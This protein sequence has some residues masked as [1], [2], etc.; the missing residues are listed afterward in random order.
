MYSHSEDQIEF[1]QFIH[2]FGGK[3]EEENRWVQLSKLIPWG[4]LEE[5]Y[6]KHFSTDRGAPAKSARMAYGSLII[7]EKCKFVDE[8]L[9]DQIK[10]NPYLQ[11]FIGLKEYQ[12]TA[13]LDSSTLV[14]FRKRIS[15]KDVQV[16]IES[17]LKKQGIVNDDSD[18]EKKDAPSHQGQLL[19]DASCAPADISF[20]TDLKLLNHSRELTEEIIDIL[21]EKGGKK[22]KK[23]RTY[24]KKARK[25]FLK[26]IRRKKTS[27]AMLRSANQKQLSFVQRNLR[28]I[29]QLSQSCCLSVLPQV[30]YKKLLVISEVVRQ[31]A[32]MLENSGSVEGRIVNLAQPHIRPIVRGKAGAKTEFGAKISLSVHNGFSFLHRVSFDNYNEGGDLIAQAEYYKSL[33][34]F[35]PESIHADK[36]YRNR[37]NRAYCRD[38]GIRLSGP[39]LGRPSKDLAKNKVQKALVRKDEGIRNGVE[40]KFGQAKR[41]FTLAKVMGK[42]ANTS[43]T[44]I[45]FSIL[46]LNL[47]KLLLFYFSQLFRRFILKKA[48]VFDSKKQLNLWK[49]SFAN[50]IQKSL[51]KIR[52]PR[53]LNYLN[54]RFYQ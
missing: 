15:V 28:H 30:L 5:S 49:K 31:Q 35:Y 3:L 51:L 10:E 52:F 39:S 8:E 16:L 18:S 25:E 23:P 50:S 40:G 34:G 43:S 27:K 33:H 1:Y 45:A 14:D 24:R 54:F 19:I 26:I 12:A 36:I 41:R 22:E 9:I 13:P 42:L 46:V 11:F 47:E 37:E 7:Q 21:Y 29:D 32:W 6:K 20:P 44:K 38:K 17:M 4:V 48:V 53:N 2:P